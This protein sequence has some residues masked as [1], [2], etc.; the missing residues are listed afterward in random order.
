MR[1]E[2]RDISWEEL[3]CA[4]IHPILVQY[5][6]RDFSVG[7]ALEIKFCV[8]HPVEERVARTGKDG[9]S[10]LVA[11]S[12]H[13]L[14]ILQGYFEQP[15]PGHLITPEIVLE[16]RAREVNLHVAHRRV[17][18]TFAYPCGDMVAAL[19]Q[20]HAGHM[21]VGIA[22]E[23]DRNVVDIGEELVLRTGED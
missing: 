11:Q 12:R 9:E 19:M 15:A 10:R 17:G 22:R 13:E 16:E 23:A 21:A 2:D 6:R 5:Y 20:D 1:G 3:G 8:D 14:V 18:R 4:V 7:I